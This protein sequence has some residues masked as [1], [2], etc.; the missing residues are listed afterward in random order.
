[1]EQN[2]HLK[3]SPFE[4]FNGANFVNHQIIAI[5]FNTILKL[6]VVFSRLSIIYVYLSRFS[7][8]FEMNHKLFA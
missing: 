5:R 6:S 2:C 7:F 8:L 1:M 3:L 4:Q